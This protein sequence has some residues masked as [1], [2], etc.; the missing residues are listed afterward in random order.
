MERYYSIICHQLIL[1]DRYYSILSC[2]L[3]LMS[4][5]YSM[6]HISTTEVHELEEE[7]QD[8]DTEEQKI[9][10]RKL[11]ESDLL[12][13]LPRWMDML[14]EGKLKKFRVTSWP[15]MAAGAASTTTTPLKSCLD[16]KEE[17]E[18]VNNSGG[19]EGTSH[20]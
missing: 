12:R 2:Q 20:F 3:I 19:S 14:C 5:Y 17:E 1:M 9:N 7:E 8:S 16:S 15:T 10:A 6:Y 18:E 4:R 13:S 11:F